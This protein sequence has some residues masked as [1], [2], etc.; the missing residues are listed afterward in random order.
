MAR[1]RGGAPKKVGDILAGLM[2]KRA[3]ARGMQNET[4]VAGWQRVAGDRL[5]SRSRVAQF[6][7]GVLTI[8]VS[9]ATQRYELEAFK[10]PQLLQL[11]QADSALP[12]VR[13]LTFRVG[14]FST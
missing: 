7:D 10:G 4:M 9:S 3:Y 2:Q 13:S 5:A 11:L 14:N 6:R 12:L 8:E 1:Y